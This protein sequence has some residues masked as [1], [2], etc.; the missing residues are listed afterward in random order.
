MKK[1]ATNATQYQNSHDRKQQKSRSGVIDSDSEEETV[2]QPVKVA[3]VKKSP[4]QP[5]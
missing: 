1:K 2:K 3:P 4:V 5:P